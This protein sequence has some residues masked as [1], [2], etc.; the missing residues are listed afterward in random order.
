VRDVHSRSHPAGPREMRLARRIGVA[1]HTADAHG[2][3]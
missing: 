3:G 1:D 2:A